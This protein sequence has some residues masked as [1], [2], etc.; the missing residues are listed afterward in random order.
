MAL[1][2][3]IVLLLLVPLSFCV[4]VIEVEEFEYLCPDGVLTKNKESCQGFMGCV[5]ANAPFMCSDGTCAEN[6]RKC[7][8]KYSKEQAKIG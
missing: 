2:N 6:E 1:F 5:T 8:L 3:S 7:N 4:K